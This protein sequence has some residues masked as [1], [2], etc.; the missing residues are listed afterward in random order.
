MEST[1]N[2]HVMLYAKRGPQWSFGGVVGQAYHRE[3][4][5]VEHDVVPPD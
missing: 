2:I 4:L 1:K 3:C 5:A